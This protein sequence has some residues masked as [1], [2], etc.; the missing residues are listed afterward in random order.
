MIKGLAV[1]VCGDASGPG[2]LRVVSERWPDSR[3]AVRN[4]AYTNGARRRGT[5][6]DRTVRISIL[7]RDAIPETG[8]VGADYTARLN[9]PLAVRAGHT[10]V[11]C[12]RYVAIREIC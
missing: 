10:L 11:S 9:E 1:C 5:D 12:S 2:C 6:E 3:S 4:P 8:Y 7:A